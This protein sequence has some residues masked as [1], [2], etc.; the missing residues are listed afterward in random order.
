[1]A[2]QLHLQEAITVSAVEI[3]AFSLRNCTANG[4]NGFTSGVKRVRC[5]LEKRNTVRYNN[6][7]RV[8]AKTFHGLSVQRGSTTRVQGEKE[9][10]LEPRRG[11]GKNIKHNAYF[12]EIKYYPINNVP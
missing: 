8:G 4:V 7:Q 5:E 3:Y 12:Y 1:M 11:A 6:V 2:Q 10:S 9:R